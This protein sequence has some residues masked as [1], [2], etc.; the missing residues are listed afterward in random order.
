MPIQ[1]DRDIGKLP[2]VGAALNRR[3]SRVQEGLARGGLQRHSAKRP[4]L[5]HVFLRRRNNYGRKPRM[6][7]LPLPDPIPLVVVAFLPNWKFPV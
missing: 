4:H 2:A 3:Q 5:A 7:R 1:G 6:A